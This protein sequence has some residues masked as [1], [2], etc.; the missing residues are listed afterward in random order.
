MS[1][2]IIVAVTFD[3][4]GSQSTVAK[5]VAHINSNADVGADDDA[6]ATNDPVAFSGVPLAAELEALVYLTESIG[7]AMQ[8][9]VPRLAHSWYLRKASSRRALRLKNELIRRNIDQ[10]LARLAKQGG[11]EQLRCAVDQILLREKAMAQSR[12]IQPDFHKRAIYDEL[13]G[14]I[15]GGHDTTSATLAWWVKYMSRFQNVQSRL[16]DHL[17]DAHA[18]ARTQ[19]RLP[20]VDEITH[21]SIPYLDAVMEETLRYSHIV[22]ILP[23]EALVDTQVLG[24]A[25]PKGTYVIFLN[26]AES[27]MRPGFDGYEA[28]QTEEA[29]RAKGRYKPWEPDHIGE[30]M[31]ERWLRTGE[32]GVG[33]AGTGPCPVFDK[34]MGPQLPFGA[35]PRACFGRK[36]AYLSMRI[37]FTLLTWS[38]EFLE[39]D[40]ALN[41]FDVQESS[42]ELP[43]ACYVKLRKIEY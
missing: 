2:D 8:S 18:I 9:P 24:Y 34:T 22:P 17:Y 12:H 7:V 30:F 35:G 10:A 29:R 31:P 16:R 42:T 32:G 4:P 38:F 41:S 27:F 28:R 3:F 43:E 23:R 5:Q 39:L 33:S 25:I 14:F 19:G 26:D 6:E 13:F 37:A 36:L 1:L 20:T 40:D 11:Q 15:V 21:A